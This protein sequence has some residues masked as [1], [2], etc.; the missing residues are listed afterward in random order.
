MLIYDEKIG[1]C[2]FLRKIIQIFMMFMSFCCALE[3]WL[4]GELQG[5]KTFKK[6]KI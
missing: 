3:L 4:L 6:L 5:L 1:T 2:S